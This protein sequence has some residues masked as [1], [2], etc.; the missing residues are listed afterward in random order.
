M[1]LANHTALVTRDGR[2]VPVEDS[3][4]P[5]TDASGRVIGVVIVFHDVTEKRRAEEALRESEARMRILGDNLPEGAIY[6]YLH[7]PDGSM[8]FEFISA[9]IER[10]IGV[11]SAEIIANATALHATI[12]PEDLA[13]LITAE[14]V[15]RDQLTQFE[16]EVRQRHRLTGE[17]RWSLLRSMPTRLAD[18]STVWDGIQLDITERKRTEEA[19]RESEERFKLSIEA[20]IDGLWDWSLTTDGA[21]FSPAYYRVLGYEVNEF[22]RRAR[23]GGR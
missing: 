10:I 14:A 13:Q 12:L 23:A 11:P 7:A 8:H 15:F 18:G 16:M 20:T 1:E 22:P 3:A 2:E 5:I 19:L 6:R 21:Y 17:I 4:A 9:G